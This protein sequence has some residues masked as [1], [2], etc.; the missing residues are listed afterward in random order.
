MGKFGSND[1]KNFKPHELFL[2][3]KFVIITR[4]IGLFNK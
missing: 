4:K 1:G 3:L 2:S